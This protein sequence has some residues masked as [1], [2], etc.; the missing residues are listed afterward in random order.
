MKFE[1]FEASFLIFKKDTGEQ[2]RATSTACFQKVERI[3]ELLNCSVYWYTNCQFI[4]IAD[5]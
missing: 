3:N 1:S 2:I 4:C 5:S